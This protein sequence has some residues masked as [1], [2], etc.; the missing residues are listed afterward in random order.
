ML[1]TLLPQDAHQALLIGRLW[2]PDFGAVVC[3]VTPEDVFD[4]SQLAPTSSQLLELPELAHQVGAFVRS[5][6]APRLAS[7]PEALANSDETCRDAAQAWFM[8]PCDLQAV[9]A[10]GVT[11]VASMLERVIE[12]QARGD[13]SRAEAVRQA[14]VAS[15]VTTCAAWYPV[16]PNRPGSKKC[17]WPKECGRNTWKWASGQTLKFSPKPSP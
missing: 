17:C 14:V 8:A 5:G 3:A 15:L 4:L 1:N 2:V 7:T 13:A 10:A 16:P 9:K 6:Q 12:E 11:F